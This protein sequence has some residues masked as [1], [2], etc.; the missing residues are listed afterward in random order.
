ME[1]CRSVVYGV[2]MQF[3]ST[4]YL[5]RENTVRF[6][7]DCGDKFRKVNVLLDNCNIKVVAGKVLLSLIEY[8]ELNDAIHQIFQ[9]AL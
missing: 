5:F 7:S 6:L 8:I 1:D 2:C 9:L 3:P 4:I